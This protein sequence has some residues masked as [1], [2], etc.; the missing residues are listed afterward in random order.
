MEACGYIPRSRYKKMLRLDF[1]IV[2]LI[3]LVSALGLM[4]CSL[5]V[6]TRRMIKKQNVTSN[7]RYFTW[8]MLCLLVMAILSIGVFGSYALFYIRH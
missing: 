6:R 2:I 8:L 1:P 7:E 5:V 3:I 4:L